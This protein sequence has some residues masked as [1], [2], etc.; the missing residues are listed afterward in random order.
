MKETASQTNKGR[1]SRNEN[2]QDVFQVIKTF[3]LAGKHVLLIDDIITTGATIEA[4]GVELWKAGI[5][6][7]SIAAVA[8][9]D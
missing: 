7:L 6:N 4:C 3:D 5:G 1:L 9:A 8:F 2:M